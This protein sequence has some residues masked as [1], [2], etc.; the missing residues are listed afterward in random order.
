MATRNPCG[1][2]RKQDNP[3]EVW[4]ADG[5]KWKV[6][7]KYQTPVKERENGYARWLCAVSSPYTQ[8]GVDIGDVYVKD[9]VGS[10]ICTF[11]DTPLATAAPISA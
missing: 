6:L 10:A 5:W 9:I 7:K 8:G 4:E 1:R 2:A 11:R 3:Y